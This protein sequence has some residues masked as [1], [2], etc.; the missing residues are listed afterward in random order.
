MYLDSHQDLLVVRHPNS[1]VETSVLDV[2]AKIP[3]VA[4]PNRLTVHQY[5]RR[6]P[7]HCTMVMAAVSL[8]V[9]SPAHAT[10]QAGSSS[11]NSGINGG[12]LT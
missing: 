3:T 9:I 2:L 4:M 10:K 6:I 12:S 7:C 1:R 11:Q 5:G 8:E